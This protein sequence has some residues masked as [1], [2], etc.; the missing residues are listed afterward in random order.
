[1]C[2][3]I[4]HDHDKATRQASCLRQELMDTSRSSAD[5]DDDEAEFCDIIETKSNFQILQIQF[6]ELF[7]RYRQT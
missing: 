1:M 2:V 7:C 4:L 6:R 3:K 5:D